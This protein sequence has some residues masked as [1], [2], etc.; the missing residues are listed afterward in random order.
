MRAYWLTGCVIL[1]GLI[2]IAVQADSGPPPQPPARVLDEALTV[3]LG[4]LARRANGVPPLRWNRQ[5]TDAAR[6]FSWDSVENRPEP[7]C[8]HQDTNG[9]W[10]SDRAPIFGYKGFAGAEN[11]FC[12]Y[13]TPQDAIDGWMNSPG[14]RAN[15]LDPNS[16]EIGLGYYLRESD[17]RGYVTQDFG[18]D[19]A[20]PPVIIENEAVTT[21]TPLVNLYIYDRA[22]AG[23]FYSMGPAAEMQVAN[24]ACVNGSAWEP[25][26]TERAWT[27][28]SGEGWRQVMVKTRDALSRTLTV[29]DSIYLGAGVPLDDLGY[30]QMSTTQDFVTINDLDGGGLPYAQFSP[31]WAV[32]HTYGT[33]GLLWGSGQVATETDAWGG[34]AYQLTVTNTGESAAWVWTTDFVKDAPLTAYMRLK[35]ADNTSPNEVA[36][37]SVNTG[38]TRSLKGIDF[39]AANQYQEFPLD[40]TFPMTETFLIFDFARTGQTDVTVDAVTIF[41]IAQPFLSPMAWAV[42]G[43]NYRGQGVWVRFADGSDTFTPF[44]E[45]DTLPR[46]F[47]VAP[48]SLTFYAAPNDSPPPPQWVSVARL[49]KT[50]TYHASATAGWLQTL[51]VG[52]SVQ[53]SVNPSGLDA[54]VYQSAVL[55]QAT[56]VSYVSVPVTLVVADDFVYLPVV[57]KGH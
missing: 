29:S 26:I 41:S 5:L 13:V 30:A 17:G 46:F 2:A 53:V 21:T 3:Y 28:A 56:G 14:H 25:Y 27:L 4:N 52:G 49:C 57:M 10:P 18:V 9:Q 20:S 39:L 50:F 47:V 34:T 55:L 12:G 23:G 36:R 45:A 7:Y 40:F 15:L 24:D 1:V 54:G 11:A 33:F 19:E 42:P 51:V 35:A 22:S 8:G 37:I 38:E 48:E 16:R 31:G 32:D 43:G 6:W 44:T